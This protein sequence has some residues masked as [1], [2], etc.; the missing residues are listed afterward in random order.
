MSARLLL[1]LALLTLAQAASAQDA[2]PSDAS[3][4]ATIPAPVVQI[5][6]DS[7]A[8]VT[9]P[10]PVEPA[11][12][13]APVVQ[14]PVNPAPQADVPVS[15]AAPAPAA[16]APVA[17]APA[18]VAVTE[19]GEEIGTTIVGDQE[20]PIGL[21][22]TPWK[23]DYAE[24]GLDRPARLLDEAMEPIDPAT[25]RRQIEYYETITEFRRQKR[26]EVK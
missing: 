12:I 11:P 16:A 2:A 7:A 24:R 9:P 26:G 14:V 3:A 17:A 21:Y 10:P 5:N 15:P 1:F 19:T 23:D 6:G 13:P 20:S 4:P 22:I 18:P 25:F 8:A